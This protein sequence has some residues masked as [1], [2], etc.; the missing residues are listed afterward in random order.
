M[1][2]NMNDEFEPLPEQVKFTVIITCIN[3]KVVNCQSKLSPILEA[4][5][6]QR[7]RVGMALHDHPLKGKSTKDRPTGT[8]LYTGGA[9]TF[10]KSLMSLQL[11]KMYL[12]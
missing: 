11:V 5:L 3:H 4:L 6:S 12:L 10:V 8:S 7:E 9:D 1:V 2:V